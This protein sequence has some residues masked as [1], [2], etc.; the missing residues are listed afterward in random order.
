MYE[1]VLALAVR[2][3]AKIAPNLAR[4]AQ[5]WDETNEEER[6]GE[7]RGVAREGRWR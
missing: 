3:I 2:S 1:C 7:R 5:I 6:R 4:P